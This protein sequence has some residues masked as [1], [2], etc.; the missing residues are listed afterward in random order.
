MLTLNQLKEIYTNSPLWLKK[1]YAS[2]PYSIRNGYEYRKWNKFLKT[3]VNEEEYELLKFKETIAFAYKNTKFYKQVL[4]NLGA[5]PEE[6]NTY[7]DIEKLPVIDKETVRNHFNDFLAVNYPNKKT[8][9]VTTGGTSGSPMKYIQSKNVYAKEIAFIHNFFLKNGAYP[10][11]KKASFK[12][13]NEDLI[14]SSEKQFWYDNPVNNEIVFSA[15]YINANTIEIYIRKLNELKVQYL[16]GFTSSMLFLI[17]NM[18]KKNVFLDYPL[19]GIYLV[20]ESFSQKD[21]DVIK[22]F[23]KCTVASYYGH[24]ERL[25]FATSS[26]SK[27]FN[28]Q[29]DRRYGLFE[30]INKNK[31]II[32]VNNYHGEIVGTSFDNYAMPLIR[33]KTGDFTEYV[34]YPNRTISL[35]QS[36][37]N[38]EYIDCK[39]GS[40]IA[41]PSLILPSEM[42]KLNIL[43][44]QL[45]QVSLENC[46]LLIIPGENFH[47]DNIQI[48]R[49]SIDSRI[50]LILNC[51][52]KIVDQLR[53][54]KRGKHKYFIKDL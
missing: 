18:K 19:K 34:D 47:S 11:I 3:E 7:K 16:Y 54:T 2:V 29:V 50:G 22:D 44:Y 15:G 17:Y 4:D 28:Y 14:D 40:K 5:D 13:I 37:R 23:F 32:T 48:L 52:I 35:I 41:F 33:Y 30:L 24:S 53:T 43:K 6:I 38:Q 36:P 42:Y 1:I 21:I 20:S 9:F 10:D 45:I 26:K 31:S 27:P 12:G 25:V 39:D 46:V 49:K 8:F 51:D